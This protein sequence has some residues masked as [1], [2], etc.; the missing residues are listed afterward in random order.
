MPIPPRRPAELNKSTNHENP[1]IFIE[2]KSSL[3]EDDIHHERISLTD[4]GR[5]LVELESKPYK[6]QHELLMP[7]HKKIIGY[8]AIQSYFRAQIVNSVFGVDISNNGD[9]M[10]TSGKYTFLEVLNTHDDIYHYELTLKDVRELLNR[11]KRS[12]N[13]HHLYE[14]NGPDGLYLVGYSAIQNYCNGGKV[15]KQTSDHVVNPVLKQPVQT[16][17]IREVD[18]M[19]LVT[20]IQSL[21][22]EPGN[23]KAIHELSTV[24]K[25]VMSPESVPKKGTYAPYNVKF[26]NG[27]WFGDVDVQAR[28]QDE[29][30]DV[31]RELKLPYTDIVAIAKRK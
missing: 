1:Y 6:E 8:D 30:L 12:V 23:E 14:L 15:D 17:F 24:L 28:N 18:I 2:V 11:L 31:F 16:G 22:S 27:T 26:M 10:T 29:A 25:Y 4:V 20:E 3:S 5:L 21:A 13:N 9:T 7:N 19:R